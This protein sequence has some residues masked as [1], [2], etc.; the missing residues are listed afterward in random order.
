[1]RLRPNNCN[2]NHFKFVVSGF[3]LGFHCGSDWL[4]NNKNSRNNIILS[5]PS[6][7]SFAVKNN[8]QQPTGS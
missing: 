8:T 2:V 3:F 1:M 4:K 7:V 6:F 5:V